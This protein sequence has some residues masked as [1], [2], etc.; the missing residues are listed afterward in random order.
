MSPIP[1]T[2]A[3]ERRHLVAVEGPSATA[4]TGDA[5]YAQT[6]AP[7]DPPTW[8]CAIAPATSGAME[9][10]GAGTTSSQA[11][12]I[13]TGRHHPGITTQARVLFDGR[14]LHV[15][16]VSNREERGIQTDLVCGEVVL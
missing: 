6:W 7:L 5:S 1:T 4:M 13:L 8:Y 9:R 12:H 16:F 3:G 10:L 11:T 15:L 2:A 14:V